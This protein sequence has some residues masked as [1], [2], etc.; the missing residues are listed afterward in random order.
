MLRA[1]NDVFKLPGD[2]KSILEEHPDKEH[3]NRN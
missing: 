3:K 1:L 2:E